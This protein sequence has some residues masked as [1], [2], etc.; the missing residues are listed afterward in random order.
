VFFQSPVAKRFWCEVK[1]FSGVLV[2]NLHPWS[3]ATDVLR[4]G[5]CSSTTAAM[6]VCGAW[7]LWTGSNGRRHGRKVWEPGA[8]SRYISSMIEELASLKML[9]KQEKPVRVLQ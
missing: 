1:K 8:S 6:V 5:V 9:A 2:P 3:W 7:T 4:A